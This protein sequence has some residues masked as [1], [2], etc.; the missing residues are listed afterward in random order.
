MGLLLCLHSSRQKI[1]LAIAAP[2]QRL[3][4][5][6]FAFSALVRTHGRMFESTE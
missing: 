4:L 2:P 1:R 3:V 6:K 5:T